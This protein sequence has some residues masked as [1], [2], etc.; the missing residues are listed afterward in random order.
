ML[1]ERG[2]PADGQDD[3]EARWYDTITSYK[4][5]FKYPNVTRV[6]PP[7][8]YPE[9][10]IGSPMHAAAAFGH[11]EIVKILIENG[12]AV[13][14]KSHYWETPATLARLRGYKATWEYLL[15]HGAIDTEQTTVC[16]N[17]DSFEEV[18]VDHDG[19]TTFTDCGM[20]DSQDGNDNDLSGA[21]SNDIM[22]EE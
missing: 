3:L 15:L 22:M 8:S 17:C 16:H 11:T 20:L 9:E 7:F 14:V 1:L 6:D 10:I 13:N 5:K 4:Y 12:A 18:D 21:I 19:D 2:L